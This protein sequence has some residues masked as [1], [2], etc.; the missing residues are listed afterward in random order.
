M[1]ASAAMPVVSPTMEAVV[2]AAGEGRRLRPL[3]ETYAKPVLP[4]DGRPV[5]AMLLRD[6]AAARVERATVVTGHLAEQV[7]ALVGDGRDF[8]LEVRFVRQ[9]RPDGS[10]DAVGRALTAGAR[11][12][13][14]VTAADTLYA[15]GDV[16]RFAELAGSSGRA[17]AHA[18]RKGFEPSP[19]RP[20]LRVSGGLVRRVYDLDPR[21]ELTSAPLWLLGERLVPF[22]DGLS[23]PPFELKDAFQRAIDAGEGVA[24]I[25]IGRTRDLTHPAD[26]ARENFP[27]LH[28]LG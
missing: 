5:V 6:L 2:M 23:G 25:E 20:G 12:P 10:A 3:S 22:L 15:P 16:A 28:A 26:L 17:G 18:A 21:L 14:L 9:P 19:A 24:A 1:V 4:I 27:Y 7:E 8:G 11:P 13:L